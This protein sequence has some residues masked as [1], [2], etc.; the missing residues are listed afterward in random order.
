MPG[1]KNWTNRDE[2]RD[3]FVKKYASGKGG[4]K[5]GDFQKYYS[6]YMSQSQG[7]GKQDSTVNLIATDSKSD[8]K[9]DA[10]KYYKN[11]MPGVKNWT[12]QDDV[13]DAFVKKYAG[14]YTNYIKKQ[15]KSADADINL[16]SEDS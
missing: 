5:G 14:S 13:R 7:G 3:A 8:S 4:S 1:V 16:N 2:V 6:Q 12:D 9:D 10:K 15:G 11:Y